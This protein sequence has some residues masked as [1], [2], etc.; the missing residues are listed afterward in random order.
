MPS[1]SLCSLYSRGLIS[2]A[3]GKIFN[4]EDSPA[5]AAADARTGTGN[6]G[7]SCVAGARPAPG[8]H[9]AR[10]KNSYARPPPVLIQVSACIHF[11]FF[12]RVLTMA[13]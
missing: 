8:C 9:S 6:G 13:P 10:R 7:Y 1:C 3:A 5:A 4:G 12:S 11:N 2:A